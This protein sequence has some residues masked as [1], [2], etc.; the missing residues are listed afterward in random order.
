MQTMDKQQTGKIS[1]RKHGKNHKNSL[2]ASFD[3][4]VP[5]RGALIDIYGPG[6]VFY[7]NRMREKAKRKL[8]TIR[9]NRQENEKQK[10]NEK[11]SRS[12]L[13]ILTQSLETGPQG[14]QILGTESTEPDKP[15]VFIT[16]SEPGSDS[17]QEDGPRAGR[18]VHPSVFKV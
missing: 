6:T 18:P 3:T 17:D 7:R 1:G 13:A 10:Q 11:E 2:S 5:T 16:K 8:N 12:R 4:F 9:G 15:E 14:L